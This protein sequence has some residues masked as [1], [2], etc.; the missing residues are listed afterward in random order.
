[1]TNKGF[2]GD[3]LLAI[4]LKGDCDIL[5]RM[6]HGK[7]CTGLSCGDCEFGITKESEIE[8]VLQWLNA[9]HEEPPLLENGDGLQPGDWIMVRDN[10]DCNWYKR[11]FMCYFNHRFY[12]VNKIEQTMDE[13]AIFNVSSWAQ[14]R[15]PMEG[16]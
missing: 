15:L 2:Y 1:M 14:A 8:N 11:Q 16:E 6:V 10:E 5:Y 4:A 3:K 7:S 9:E 13:Y 12:C